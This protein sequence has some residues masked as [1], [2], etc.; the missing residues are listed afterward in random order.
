M[1]TYPPNNTIPKKGINYL[2]NYLSSSLDNFKARLLGYRTY[3]AML[4]QTGTDAPIATVLENSL[5][6]Q[7]TYEYDSVGTYFAILNESLFDT[8]TSTVDGSKVEVFMNPASGT[9]IFNTPIDLA[10]YPVFVF[11]V[12]IESRATGILNDDILGFSFSTVLE[13]R[14]YNK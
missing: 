10:A 7:V 13:I 1:A 9:G 3:K 14:V 5:G 2:W 11:V 4:S 12:G 6:I 8:P